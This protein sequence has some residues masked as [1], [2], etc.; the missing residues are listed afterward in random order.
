MK[1]GNLAHNSGCSIQ[2]IRYYET[3]GLLETPTRTSANYRSYTQKHLQQ[4]LFIKRC[5]A[6]KLSLTE[7]QYLID[8]RDQPEGDCKPITTLIDQHLAEVERH[9]EELHSLKH[10]LSELRTQCGD[11]KTMSQCG[12]IKSLEVVS[13][14]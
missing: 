3:R 10:Q 12:I 5:R 7:I 8:S 1:I 13:D 11:A 2:T 4:L 9:I 6:L 14:N